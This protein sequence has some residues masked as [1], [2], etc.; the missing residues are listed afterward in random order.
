MNKGLIKAEM[1][2]AKSKYNVPSVVSCSYVLWKQNVSKI[3]YVSKLECRNASLRKF[4]FAHF[5]FKRID[6][7]KDR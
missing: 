3:T 2:L 7:D 6:Y 4:H 5:K 1:Y